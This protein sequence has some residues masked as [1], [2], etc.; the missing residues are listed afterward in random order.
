MIRG[1][2]GTRGTERAFP[3]HRFALREGWTTFWLVALVVLIAT[4]SIQFAPWGHGL[5]L[6]FVTAVLGL[7]TGL[8]LSRIERL[9]MVISHILS[10]IIGTTVVFVQMI[11]FLSDTIGG[12]REKIEY[13]W[14]HWQH[15]F[16]VVSRGHRVDDLPLFV[17]FLTAVI[18][19]MS[20]GSVWLVFRTGWVWL[21][22]LGP[23]II[24]LGI[25]GYYPQVPGT[26]VVFY[27]FAAILLV[28]RFSYVRRELAWRRNGV[29]YPG[30]L[31]WR[32][33][34]VASC[35]AVAV[36]AAGWLVPLS[37]QGDW[38]L[39]KWMQS[40]GPW[41]EFGDTFNQWVS[42]KRAPVRVA[43]G[44]TEF[45]NQFSLGGR[46]NLTDEP[47][48][49]V[50]G[51]AGPYLAAKRYNRFTGTGW[52]SDISE[53]VQQGPRG[54]VQ[55]QVF[56]GADEAIPLPSS[57]TQARTEQALDI[58]VYRPE[59]AS[60]FTTGEPSRVSVPTRARVATYWY[61]HQ[62]IDVTT[63][64]QETVPPDL[65]PL[66]QLLKTAD[67]SDP[68]VLA[69]VED[70]QLLLRSRG[71]HTQIQG[72]PDLTESKLVFSGPLPIYS[73][74]E[75]LDATEGIQRGDR[76]QVQALISNANPRQLREAGQDYPDEIKSRYLQLPAY[77]D[78]TKALARDLAERQDNPYDIAVSIQNYLRLN[79][80]YN[81]NIS[82]PPEG[83][84]LVDYFLFESQQGYCTYYASA[85]AE[86]LRI[87]GI[88]SRVVTG[89]YPAA[90]DL[91]AGGYLYRDRN[92]HAW[93]EA[94]FPGYGWISFEPTAA[95]VPLSHGSLEDLGAGMADAVNPSNLPAGQ[96]ETSSEDAA[97]NPPDADGTSQVG[98]FTVLAKWA[99]WIGLGLLAVLG[100]GLLGLWLW[101]LRG[102]SAASRFFMRMHRGASWS[103]VPSRPSMTPY[104]Y[105][106][107][108]AERIPGSEPDVRYLADLYVRERYGRQPATEREL[109]KARQSWLHLRVLF[110][111]HL[112]WDRWRRPGRQNQDGG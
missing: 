25:L 101:G 33:L 89:F 98:T 87:L 37:P 63:S 17:L 48:V 91:N 102:L 40:N 73:E 12:R 23:G 68:T 90:Y 95:R 70:E 18:W 76:Y 50:R 11:A 85:M 54:I 36:I 24:L 112:L 104:E 6:L 26:L 28:M 110:F 19:V 15:W 88:P 96:L 83:K 100:S 105:A 4:W 111:R 80:A 56:F 30:S 8:V 35:L 44:L 72:S 3:V 7:F 79:L 58:E 67:L 81:D 69:Q 109:W 99:L 57:V 1:T 108:I 9:P 49:L 2:A 84:D 22:A 86:M 60:V 93:V 45:R 66:V 10:L 13:L 52:E 34:G 82:S 16:E 47:V 39:Q 27:L 41:R 78:R 92:A 43:S 38:A 29:P 65:W 31:P 14:L 20:Y 46:L 75:G 97:D 32:G 74:I 64:S 106:A 103:G 55:P 53:P 62:Q 94:Y 42:P 51:D 59:G 21:T 71:I 77:S 107:M 61:D 5:R